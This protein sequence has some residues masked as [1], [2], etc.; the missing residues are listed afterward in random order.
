MPTYSYQCP[1]N[2]EY[3]KVLKMADYQKPTK[4]PTCNKRGKKTLAVSQSEP[5]FTQKL[6]PYYDPALGRVCNSPTERKQIMVE[7]GV[8]PKEGWRRTTAKQERYLMS[9]RLH[10]RP[11][12]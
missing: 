2:H 7:L 8:Q 6:Y 3:D 9:Q 10:L 12:M 1:N 5:T 11:Q 4:C